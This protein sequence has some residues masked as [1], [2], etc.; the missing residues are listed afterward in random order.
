MLARANEADVVPL[1]KPRYEVDLQKD[2]RVSMSDGVGL[3]ADVYRPIGADQRLPTM[4]RL[5]GLLLMVCARI[6]SRIRRRNSSIGPVALNGVPGARLTEFRN[7]LHAL[8]LRGWLALALCRR[9]SALHAYAQTT[10]PHLGK[11]SPATSDRIQ[12]RI[13]AMS[14]AGNSDHQGP[15]GHHQ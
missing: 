2:V 6:V 8:E 1:P 9:W 7:R 13:T 11:R 15:Q 3:Y 4:L 14:F 10:G 12:G 5:S